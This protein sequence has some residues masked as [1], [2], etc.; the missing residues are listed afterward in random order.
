MLIDVLCD[1]NRTL[2]DDLPDTRLILLTEDFSVSKHFV[3]D[4]E[5][6]DITKR[7]KEQE[8]VSFLM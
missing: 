6:F 4:G 2:L 3:D 1:L 5:S 7:E 8:N